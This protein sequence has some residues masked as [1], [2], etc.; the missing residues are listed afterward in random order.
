VDA[1]GYGAASGAPWRA[2]MKCWA[3]ARPFRPARR[4]NTWQQGRSVV[5]R[6]WFGTGA[7][8]VKHLR[9]GHWSVT[10]L[11]FRIAWRRAFARSRSAASLGRHSYT[12]LRLQAFLRGM[13][14]GLGAP[15]NKTTAQFEGRLRP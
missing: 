10:P 1:W 12:W 7:M 4:A 3:W 5:Y 6:N 13:L 14:A 8:L 2:S 11:L 9:C 15:L